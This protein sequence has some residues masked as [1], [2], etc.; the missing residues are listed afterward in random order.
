MVRSTEGVARNENEGMYH[1]KGRY[2]SNATQKNKKQILQEVS[3]IT[4]AE[5]LNYF[6][7]TECSSQAT[8]SEVIQNL[9]QRSGIA[10]TYY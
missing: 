3:Y 4:L 1:P 9:S 10:F 5:W 8:I 7:Q 2:S 6:V